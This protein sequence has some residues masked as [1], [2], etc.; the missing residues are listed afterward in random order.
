MGRVKVETICA[1]CGKAV[2]ARSYFGDHVYDGENDTSCNI[3][4]GGDVLYGDANGDAKLGI[5]DILT[6][7]KEL[8]NK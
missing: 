1:L 4:G 8:V 5:A 3:C 6:I 2:E 7:F